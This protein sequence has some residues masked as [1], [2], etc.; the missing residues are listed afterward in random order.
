VEVVRIDLS[1]QPAGVVTPEEAH[2]ASIRL[3]QI[4][5]LLKAPPPQAR[6]GLAALRQAGARRREELAQ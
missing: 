3:Q 2:D 1:G 5:Q 6:D 4:K